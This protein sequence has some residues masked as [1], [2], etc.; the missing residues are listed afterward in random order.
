MQENDTALLRWRDIPVALS[1]LT[2]LPLPPQPQTAFDRQAKACWAFP[3]VGLVVGAVAVAC[4]TAALW[5]GVPAIMAAGICLFVQIAATGALHEDGLADT[6]DGFWGGWTIERRLEIMKDSSIGTYGV[7]ALLLTTGLR[8]T[9]LALLL[10][11][12]AW[13]VISVAIVSRAG[14]PAMMAALPRVRPGGLSD[15]VGA[16]PRASVVLS[17]AI[18][19][20]LLLAFAGALFAP[21]LLTTLIGIL[22]CGAIANTKLGGQ[23]GD[24]LGATQQVTE[25]VCLIVLA[26]MISS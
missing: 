25:L 4:A 21:V 20:V 18:G 3:L 12:H 6:A 10:E 11:A 16:P 9:T 17:A 19:T 7:L 23:T 14:L 15:R 5:L 8:W 22:C 24:V 2:R 26:A 13:S 1:L